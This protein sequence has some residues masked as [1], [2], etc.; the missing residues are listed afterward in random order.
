MTQQSPSSTEQRAGVSEKDLTRTAMTIIW[1]YL[2][3]KR[4]RASAEP[5]I[6]EF[7]RVTLATHP[8]P[9]RIGCPGNAILAQISSTDAPDEG[10]LKHI[11]ECGPC[12]HEYTELL[13]VV[14][15]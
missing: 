6:T 8:N 3:G 5:L 13:D 11:E 2:T 15:G 4:S 10:I 7:A 9:E 12:L 1:S 14:G